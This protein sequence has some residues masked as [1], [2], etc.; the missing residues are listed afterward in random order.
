MIS[1]MDAVAI[2]EISHLTLSFLSED[3]SAMD[4][5]RSEPHTTAVSHQCVLDTL[6]A[7]C[8]QDSVV[9]D[10]IPRLIEH[11]QHMCEGNS[12]D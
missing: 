9:H 1:E 11:V 12:N 4:T 5:D 7:V 2:M 8:T 10:V 6:A 3:G